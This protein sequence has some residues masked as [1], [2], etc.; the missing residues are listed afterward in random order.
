MPPPGWKQ[1]TYM[2]ASDQEPLRMDMDLVSVIIP[3]YR[4]ANFLPETVASLQRQTHGCWEAIIVDDGSLDDT[5]QV[6]EKIIAHDPRVR[7]FQQPNGGPSSARNLGLRMAR[8]RWIQFLDGDDLLEPRKFEIQTAQLRQAPPLALSYS[9]Y[10]HGAA[11]DPAQRVPSIRLPCRFTCTDPLVDLAL[12][13]ET[14]FSI[15]IHAPLVD[16]AFFRE[17]GIRFDESLRNHED[18][19]VWMKVVGQASVIHFVDQELAVY[20]VCEGSN[21][22]DRDRN[23][24]GFRTAIDLQLHHYRHRPDMLALLHYKA[25][26]TDWTYCKGWKFK[27]FDTLSGFRPYATLVPWPLQ[28]RLHGLLAPRRPVPAG[29]GGAQRAA[30]VTQVPP[31]GSGALHAEPGGSPKAR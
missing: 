4:Q 24:R 3:S 16:A 25:R 10:W 21:S 18:W 2:D 14:A 27:V 23:W 31:V 15:P 22:R 8:G 28:R 7:F 6:V 13:W 19:D 17:L 30:V 11:H 20:R 9:D 1:W 29:G 12:D 26:L 5:Q